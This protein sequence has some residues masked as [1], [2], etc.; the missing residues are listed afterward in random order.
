VDLEIYKGGGCWPEKVDLK[1]G[2]SGASP[3]RHF[4]N[5]DLILL[6]SG[7]VTMQNCDKI[8]YCTVAVIQVVMY[9]NQLKLNEVFG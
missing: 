1:G 5:S 7:H 8:Y 2:G 3:T 9:N 6:Y 4:S